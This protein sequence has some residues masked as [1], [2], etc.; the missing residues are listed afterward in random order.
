MYLLK[1]YHHQHRTTSYNIE[2]GAF[3]WEQN[4]LNWK[5]NNFRGV[6]KGGGEVKL[7]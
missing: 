5:I 7:Y 6:Y 2:F 3:F 4:C 1:Q